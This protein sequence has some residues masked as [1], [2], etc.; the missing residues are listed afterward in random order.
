MIDAD[1]PVIGEVPTVASMMPPAQTQIADLEYVGETRKLLREIRRRGS[2]Y[3]HISGKSLAFFAMDT[4]TLVRLSDCSRQ[5]DAEVVALRERLQK[6]QE[7]VEKL[8]DVAEDLEWQGAGNDHCP[9]CG[10]MRDEDAPDDGHK[11]DCKLW[12]VLSK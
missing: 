7:R 12:A 2:Q 8:M 11:A 1:D 9:L 4:E 3:L 5:E 10:G 6:A